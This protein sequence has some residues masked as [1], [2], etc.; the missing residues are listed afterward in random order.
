MKLYLRTLHNHW[1]IDVSK[2]PPPPKSPSQLTF[3]FK[4]KCN[5]ELP[6]QPRCNN[7]HTHLDS[8]F[9]FL[10]PLLE[11]FKFIYSLKIIQLMKVLIIKDYPTHEGVN[12]FPWTVKEIDCNVLSVLCTMYPTVVFS[13]DFCVQTKMQ[14]WITMTADDATMIV[15]I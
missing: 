10:K 13:T 14:Q 12:Y 7:E 1:D 5:N 15:I 3:V 9:S 2:Y 4:P 11:D 6:W 8:H